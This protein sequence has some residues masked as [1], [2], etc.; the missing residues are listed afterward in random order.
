VP[1]PQGL[2]PYSDYIAELNLQL[3]QSLEGLPGGALAPDGE[4]RHILSIVLIAS[5]IVGS[6]VVSFIHLPR[7]FLRLSM[8][9]HVLFDA[10][11]VPTPGVVRKAEPL[12]GAMW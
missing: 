6:L 10:D 9:V 8:L 12:F 1:L 2:K 7:G 4:I 5:D 11:A 3:E